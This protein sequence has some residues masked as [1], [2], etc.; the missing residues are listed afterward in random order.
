VDPLAA[1][2]AVA[3]GSS[4]DA[5]RLTGACRVLYCFDVGRSIDLARAAAVLAAS[6]QPEFQHKKPV[7]HG[8]G[9]PP[10]L[11]RPWSAH[12]VDVAP[13]FVAG[14]P[15][16]S[17]YDFG[18]VCVTWALPFEGGL[19]DLVR[20][21]RALYDH[22]EMLA[23]SRAL[24]HEVVD[25][26][27]DA[28]DRP[29]YSRHVEDY[30][31]LQL[32]PVAGGIAV[33]LD[34]ERGT[35]ARVLRAEERELS[36]QEVADALAAPVSYGREDV[37]LVD[38]L[39]AILVGTDTEDERLV[40]ELATVELLE[41]RV[42]DD[43]LEKEIETAYALLSRPLGRR[44]GLHVQRRELEQVARAQADDALLHEGIDNALKL[45]GDDYLARL[46]RG[47]AERFHFN[48]WDTS[49]QRK[50][51]VLRS[52]YQSLADLASHRRSEILE[53]IIILLIAVDIV[54]Y[55]TPL[56]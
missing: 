5:L 4:V 53:W 45:F 27:G 23:R 20:L 13:G 47:S 31:V 24:T 54:L 15:E 36:S 40:L 32:E 33:L 2:P 46:Y 21:S 9:M 10:P 11:R 50:L 25:A 22:A 12:P 17:V 29:A 55:F 16:V 49:I 44:W 34:R 28:V 39:A 51:G 42:L 3:V 43:Q 37:C 48:D 7:P 52:V 8:G 19:E 35:L 30:L 1:A 26:L 41:L 6:K 18:V 38:W 56:R 14:R